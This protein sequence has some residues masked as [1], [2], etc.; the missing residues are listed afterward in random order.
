MNFIQ[1]K[2]WALMLNKISVIIIIII[3]ITGKYHTILL[4][5]NSKFYLPRLTLKR[6]QCVIVDLP[7]TANILFISF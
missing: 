6:Y 7:R 1:L 5:G 3:I 2:E 4:C